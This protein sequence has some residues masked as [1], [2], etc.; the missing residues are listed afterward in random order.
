MPIHRRARRPAQPLECIHL[1]VMRRLSIPWL[2]FAAAELY[3]VAC[4]FVWPL[5]TATHLGTFLW[6]SQLFLLMPGSIAAGELVE[7]LLWESISP[8]MMGILI[9]LIGVALNALL[10]WILLRI[11]VRLSMGLRPDKSLQRTRAMKDQ[12]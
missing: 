2:C 12:A 9:P 5:F 8:L 7:G 10:F 6:G 1:N 11:R 4:W 3:A